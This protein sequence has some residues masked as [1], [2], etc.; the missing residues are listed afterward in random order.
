[1]N[2]VILIGRLTKDPELKATP[3]G[4]SVCTFTLAVDRRSTQEGS[5]AD[6]IPIVVW[7]AQ[8]ENCAKYLGK[9]SLVAVKGSISTR[10]Y[11]DNNGNKRFVTEVVAENVQFLTPKSNTAENNPKTPTEQFGSNLE[12]AEDDL[13]F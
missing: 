4:I 8:A 3:S 13:P 10:S 2:N 9:G 12:S 6:F 5:T 11:D 1:M 7:R